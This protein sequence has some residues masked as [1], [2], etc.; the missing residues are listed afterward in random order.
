MT[1]ELTL[2]SADGTKLAVRCSGHGSPIVLVHGAVGDS[3]TF[4][5]IEG[6]LAEHHSVWVY[7]RRGPGGS[8]DGSGR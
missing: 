7:A 4:T 6:R 1:T 8:G 5:L 3:D 2:T